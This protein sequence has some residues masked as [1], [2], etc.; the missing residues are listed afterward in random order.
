MGVVCASCKTCHSESNVSDTVVVDVFSSWMA[1]SSFELT[2]ATLNI[3]EARFADYA[4]KYQVQLDDFHISNIALTCELSASVPH[5]DEGSREEACLNVDLNNMCGPRPRRA[6]RPNKIGKTKLRIILNMMKR[7]GPLRIEVDDLSLL[8]ATASLAAISQ[9]KLKSDLI[10]VMEDH[11]TA[12]IEAYRAPHTDLHVDV[13]PVIGERAGISA[14]P[15]SN[16]GMFS[17]TYKSSPG[18]VAPANSAPGTAP[19]FSAP[20]SNQRV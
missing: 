1:P 16:Q 6:S 15:N 7:H 12:K 9:E 10:L 17:S 3:I 11:L 18:N 20:N 4:A 14:L 13:V 8:S 2:E 19:G 5:E